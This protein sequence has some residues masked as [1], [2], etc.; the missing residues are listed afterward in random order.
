MQGIMCVRVW[1]V[2]HG[3]CV[4]LQHIAS[5][6]AGQ[7][8]GG[9]I[10]MIDSGSSPDFHPS[11]YLKEDLGVDRIDYLFITNADQDHMSDLEGLEDAGIKVGT[12]FRNR[13][14][15]ADQIRDMK[16]VSGPLTRDATWYVNACRTFNNPVIEPF[17]DNMGGITCRCFWN[18][19]PDFKDTN[20]LSLAVFIKFGAFKILLPGDLERPGWLALLERD[21]F[22]AELAGTTVLMASHHGRRSGFCDE[23][24]DYFTPDCVVISDKPIVHTTQH[25][26]PD[27]RAVTRENGV[28]VRTT[29]KQRHVLTT[30]R[31]GWIMF[32]VGHQ[33]YHIDTEY[34]G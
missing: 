17:N 1:D 25:M 26:A 20:N 19:Y 5:N 3:C 18:N 10:A 11:T 12:L 13:S 8:I 16:L 33:S 9:R 6:G 34:E 32:T 15:T 24:F 21:D 31:D 27:Y 30:R 22:C 4:M 7:N 29:G 2:E 23:I 28:Y 14:Y